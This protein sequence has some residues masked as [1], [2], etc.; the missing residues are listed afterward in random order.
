MKEGRTQPQQPE[1]DLRFDA[2]LRLTRGTGN[3]RHGRR[4]PPAQNSGGMM[5]LTTRA[6]SRRASRVTGRA[7]RA[8]KASRERSAQNQRTTRLP[9]ARMLSLA[10]FHS[11][12]SQAVKALSLVIARAVD[13]SG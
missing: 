11:S 1:V 3:S 13:I 5:S 2:L 8:S 7:Q 10:G 4:T 6:S 12:S 9:L